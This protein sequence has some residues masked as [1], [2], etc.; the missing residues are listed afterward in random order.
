MARITNSIHFIG[1]Q[2]DDGKCTYLPCD[3]DSDSQANEFVDFDVMQLSLGS[4]PTK[5]HILFED[6]LMTIAN[7]KPTIQSPD[8]RSY[9]EFVEERVIAS[10]ETASITETCYNCCG[11]S[12]LRPLLGCLMG[13]LF[14]CSFILNK[15]KFK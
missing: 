11:A 12:L 8:I 13:C 4:L 14:C 9:E 5:P 3:V 1:T 15:L 7:I 2:K 10:S 6:I